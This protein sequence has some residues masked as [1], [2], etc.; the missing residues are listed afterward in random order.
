MKLRLLNSE[1]FEITAENGQ[2]KFRVHSTI[3]AAQSEPFGCLVAGD[4][5]ESTNRKI[6]LND[7][8]GDTV[9]RFVEFLYTQN[10]Q[11]PSPSPFS[12]EEAAHL[13]AGAAARIP[14]TTTR[15]LGQRSQGLGLHRPLTPL[16]QCVPDNLQVLSSGATYHEPCRWAVDFG[17][18]NTN[19]KE[20]LLAHAKVYALAQYKDVIALRALSLK[21][22]LSTLES[23]VKSIGHDSHMAVGIVELLGY[24][25]SNTN[26][27]DNSKEP[28]RRVVS[29]FAALNFEGLQMKKEMGDLM[30]E[31]GDLVRDLMEKVNR[32]LMVLKD[33]N[34]RLKDEN[35]ELKDKKVNAKDSPTFMAASIS[36]TPT[37]APTPLSPQLFHFTATP[38]R[39]PTSGFS[40]FR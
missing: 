2:Q 17:P 39:R 18:N 40:G 38:V 36:P 4:W 27:L 21:R 16:S 23:G 15:D 19:H 29:Q 24:V 5:K 28:M 11:Y 30:S 1:I 20:A 37:P 7:W 31:G 13:E 26:V 33:E 14:P 22:L 35:I 25:Y 34:T 3:L 12:L 9:G 8:D 32:R 10:Y 6:S